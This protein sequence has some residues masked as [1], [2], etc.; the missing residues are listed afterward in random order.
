MSVVVASSELIS[1]FFRNCVRVYSVDIL[2]VYNEDR[3]NDCGI[4]GERLEIYVSP[5]S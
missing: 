2:Q 5:Q 3:E 1:Q 4:S